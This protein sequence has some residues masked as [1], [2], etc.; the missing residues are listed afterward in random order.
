VAGRKATGHWFGGGKNA[1]VV[2]RKTGQVINNVLIE[3]ASFEVVTEDLGTRSIRTNRI[4]S[5][6]YRNLPTFPTDMLR[7]LDGTE[8]N[9][10]VTN[11]PVTISTPDLGEIRV[12]KRNLLSIIF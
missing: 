4:K 12:P 8:L 7:L 11:D 6:V 5:I 10:V 2:L 9:G 3:D 1:V